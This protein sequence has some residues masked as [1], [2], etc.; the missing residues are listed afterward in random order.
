MTMRPAII[1]IDW[2]GLFAIAWKLGTSAARGVSGVLDITWQVAQTRSA[3]ARPFS[4]FGFGATLPAKLGSA[5]HTYTVNATPRST[6]I[7]TSQFL[8][9]A[10]C[11]PFL[12]VQPIDFHPLEVG[13]GNNPPD[14]AAL[15]HGK[16]TESAVAHGA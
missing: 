7:V 13:A 14:P 10:F 16:M 3:K 9:D 2:P 15:D 8:T 12:F 4:G 1:S 5:K 11:Q 6:P